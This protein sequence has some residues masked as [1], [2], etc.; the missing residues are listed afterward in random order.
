MQ[1]NRG[2]I[3]QY[4]RKYRCEL[5][6]RLRYVH[7][8]ACIDASGHHFQKLL[9]VRSNFLNADLPK[10]FADKIKRVQACIDARGRHVQYLL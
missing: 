8:Q 2:V 9:Y 3:I 4:V 10:V 1:Q 6:R 5:M 7:V